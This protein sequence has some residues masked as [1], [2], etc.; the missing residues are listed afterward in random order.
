MRNK[1]V[2]IYGGTTL[3]DKKVSP[4][5]TD[6]AYALLHNE[7]IVL[8]TGGFESSAEVHAPLVS[9]D[10]AV[11][12]G[13]TRFASERAIPLES[14]LE[15]W[16]PE[17]DKDRKTEG[18]QRFKEGT[19][20]QLP[21]L[22]AQARRLKLVQVADA[23]VTISGHVH[24]ALVLE[25][26]VAIARPA[27]PLPFTGGDS[28]THWRDNRSYYLARLGVDASQASDWESFD[29]K[30]VPIEAAQARIPGIVDTVTR[31]MRRSCLVLMPFRDDVSND[32]VEMEKIIDGEGFHA[33]RLDR[34]LYVGDVRE[35]VR[36][37]LHECDAIV[38]DVTDRSANVMYEVGLAHAFGRDPLLLWRGDTA[39]MEKSLPFYLRPQRVVAHEDP[40]EIAAAL[41]TYLVS[42]TSST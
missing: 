18:V 16:L 9:T 13:A 5:V 4:F 8:A 32:Y 7:R 38:A 41:K 12:R 3:D 1:R 15:T 10:V 21:G 31:V 37:L 34:E 24:T 6:L 29:V 33:V 26:A 27:L 17:P 25:M 35:T 2:V 42:K 40:G 19:L 39:A 14:C 36:R 23:I 22:S 20:Q 11:L 28:R 30:D